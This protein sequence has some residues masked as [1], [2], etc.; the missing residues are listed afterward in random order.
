MVT[1]MNSSA[2]FLL[3]LTLD[4]MITLTSYAPRAALLS[5]RFPPHG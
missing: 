2:Y 5:H 1:S 3:I 4:L